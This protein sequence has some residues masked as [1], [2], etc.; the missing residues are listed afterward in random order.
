MS[1]YTLGNNFTKKVF[2][3]VSKNGAQIALICEMC[4]NKLSNFGNT[5]LHMYQNFTLKIPFLASEIS[6]VV[7][8]NEYKSGP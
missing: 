8:V 1:N 3:T 2:K 6:R 4:N 5:I 7:Q